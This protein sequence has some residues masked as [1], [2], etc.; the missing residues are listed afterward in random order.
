MACSDADACVLP[1][2]E[3]S[4]Y[5]QRWTIRGRITN[6]SALRTF[7]RGNGDGKVFH[8]HLLD[9]H[10]GEIRASFFNEAV[11]LFYEKL[12][13]GKC[14]TMSRGSARIANQQYN[15]CGHRYELT[16]EKNA[17]I[18]QADDDAEIEAVKLSIT[19]LHSVQSKPRPCKVDLCGVITAVDSIMTFT[20]KDGKELVKRNITI[21][22]HTATSLVVTLWGEQA[23]QEENIFEG[24]PVVCL[25]AVA[26]K[27]WNGGLGGSLSESGALVL[28]PSVQEAKVVQ[29][30]WSEA[31]STQ[32]LTALTV[33]GGGGGG[34]AR[35][36]NA[37]MLDLAALRSVS[38][39]VLTTDTEIYSVVC[40]LALVQLQKRGETQPLSYNACQEPKQG[41]SLP[42]N[43]RVDSSGF[44]ASCNRV[45]NVAARFNLRC[46]FADARDNAWLTTFHEAAEQVIGLKA[47][48]AQNLEQGSGGREALEGA[49]V[50]KYFEAPLQL[51]VRA[52]SETYNGEAR[53]SV[54]CIDARPVPHGQHGRAMLKEV[55][56]HVRLTAEKQ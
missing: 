26:I 22:D 38:E 24:N 43:R 7:T 55:L 9:A 27:D 31:G 8:V 28:S 50:A 13:L 10:G 30:W 19:D 52:K 15:S 18:E 5:I 39:Q 11:D 16:F 4:S 56:E 14:Y 23:K 21:A 48:E 34:A 41:R 29:R 40:R 44:C 51:T 47:E 3:I 53:T 37:K 54:S 46:R 49:I 20:S 12:Q 45:G 32:S 42:C 6:K 36:A 33:V 35:A 25:K 1:I 17:Q 2:S